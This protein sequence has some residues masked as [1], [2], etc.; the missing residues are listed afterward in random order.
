MTTYKDL[1]GNS[2]ITAYEIGENDFDGEYIDI[3]FVSGKVYTYTKNRLGEVNFEVM[4][5][6]AEAGAGLCSF[7]TKIRNS[8][9]NS[10]PTRA[11]VDAAIRTL[12]TLIS[13]HR[14]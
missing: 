2:G 3:Q 10:K 4:K 6:L 7:I 1:N 12:Q 13:E 8:Y 11:E 5:A 14:S 9:S